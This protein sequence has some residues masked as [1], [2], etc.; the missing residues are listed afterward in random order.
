MKSL[1]RPCEGKRPPSAKQKRKR[2]GPKSN[3]HRTLIRWQRP[4]CPFHAC[5][6]SLCCSYTTDCI[7]VT[8]TECEICCHLYRLQ[9]ELRRPTVALNADLRWLA[10]LKAVRISPQYCCHHGIVFRSGDKSTNAKVL[11]WK[12]KH[13]S[14]L[15][16]AA[17]ARIGPGAQWWTCW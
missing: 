10:R 14:S 15:T 3:D 11:L 16:T 8:R 7:R 6:H 9:P 1:G 12:N 17:S 5:S 13:C 2:M 4:K